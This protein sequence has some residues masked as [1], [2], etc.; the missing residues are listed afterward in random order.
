M[1]S[2]G[3]K[4][5]QFHKMGQPFMH[6]VVKWVKG[7]MKLYFIRYQLFEL[8]DLCSKK[9]IS[10]AEAAFFTVGSLLEVF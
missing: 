4:R 9:I 1:F 7:A 10:A 6:N 8:N 2:V 3:I 5:D